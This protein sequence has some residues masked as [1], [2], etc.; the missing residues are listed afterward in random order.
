MATDT[1]IGLLLGGIGTVTGA[2]SFI[3]H[4]VRS[5]HDRCEFRLSKFKVTYFAVPPGWQFQFIGK[6]AHTAEP[7]PV[8]TW[9]RFSGRLINK[10]Y[11][12]GSVE[13]IKA[14]L[15]PLLADGEGAFPE[16]DV[17]LPIRVE[18]HSSCDVRFS[19]HLTADHT[20]V[21]R[22]PERAKCSI[23]LEDQA[24]RRHRSR[25]WADRVETPRFSVQRRQD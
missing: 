22:L 4:I 2:I 5:R 19:Y 24:E 1:I 13:R 15:P 11:Q 23:I 10:G 25:F 16:G 7:P 6:A 20:A 21:Q 8:G 9:L 14:L 18:A 17:R 3:W 12:R